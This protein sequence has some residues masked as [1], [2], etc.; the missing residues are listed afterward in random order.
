[1]QL[2]NYTPGYGAAM[3][4]F[5]RQRTADTHAAFFLPHLSA[6]WRVLDAGCGPGSITLG[7]ARKLAPGQVTGVDL[8][9]SQFTSAMEQARLEGLHVD[10]R[11]ASVYELPFPNG[12]FDA[13]FSHAVMSHL[14]DPP[15]AL[16]EFHR[17][18][19]PGGLIG[20]RAGD[21][22]GLLID[23]ESDLAARGFQAYIE[24]QKK[25]GGDPQVGRKMGRL[26]RAAGFEVLKFGAAYEVITEGARSFASLAAPPFMPGF[27]DADAASANTASLFVALA[28]CEAV[29]RAV[30]SV[31]A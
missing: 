19:K 25:N 17:V 14:S 28:W 21:L 10:F 9:G 3:L 6:G 8:E 12:W 13:V 29:G 31:D 20:V 11:Q 22:G 15:A 23:A 5:F 4:D 18:L 16:R 30:K 27:G 2:N 7:L 26:L 24:Q 1:M